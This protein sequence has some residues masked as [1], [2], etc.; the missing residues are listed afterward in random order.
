MSLAICQDKFMSF[1]D[2]NGSF[3]KIFASNRAVS[4]KNALDNFESV[5][6]AVFEN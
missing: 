2:V 4:D 6:I 3:N 1:E 5:I